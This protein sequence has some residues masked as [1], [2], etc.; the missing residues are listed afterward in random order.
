M[1]S[2]ELD[3]CAKRSFRKMVCHKKHDFAL[4]VCE[5]CGLD[6]GGL[7]FGSLDFGGLD[8]WQLPE[9]AATRPVSLYTAG[10]YAAMCE[11][12]QTEVSQ[13]GREG[14]NIRPAVGRAAVEERK[15]SPW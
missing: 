13:S 14:K 2:N 9:R 10:R 6:F 12:T 5:S 11:Y 3:S 7:D 4:A 8:L 1:H 15:K